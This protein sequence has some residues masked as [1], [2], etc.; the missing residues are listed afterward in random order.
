VRKRGYPAL[1]M[2]VLDESPDAARVSS[3]LGAGAS[4]KSIPEADSAPALYHVF[5]RNRRFT[6]D[7]A[8]VWFDGGRAIV[9]AVDAE[10]LSAAGYRV[11][12]IRMEDG[13][14]A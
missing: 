8:G 13:D 9:G 1:V 4:Q 12:P 14:A 7:E 5:T 3:I 10:R 11:I 2:D 6:G